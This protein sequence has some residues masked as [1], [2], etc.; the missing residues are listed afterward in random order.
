MYR[1]IEIEEGLFQLGLADSI[2]V[3]EMTV[4]NLVG[5]K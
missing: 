5:E 3:K 1:K 2:V 4:F